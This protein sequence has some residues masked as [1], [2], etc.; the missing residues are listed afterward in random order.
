MSSKTINYEIIDPNKNDDEYDDTIETDVAKM[1][2]TLTKQYPFEKP[3]FMRVLDLEAM[4]APKF[5]KYM[6]TYI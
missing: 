2:N 6:D 4:Y 1:T 3:F 5:P